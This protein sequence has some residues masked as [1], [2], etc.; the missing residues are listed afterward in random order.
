MTGPTE[1]DTHMKPL[2]QSLAI[3][4]A[5]APAAS[6]QAGR[7]MTIH[8]LLVAVRV[9]EP[10]LS[11]DGR[12]VAYVRTTTD[13]AK[14]ARNAEIWVVPADGSGPA[15]GLIVGEKAGSAPR[16]S[17]DGKHLA[18]ISSRDGDAQVYVADA[19]GGNIRKI[20]TLSGGV[21]AP[22]VWSPD[23]TMLAFVSD[24][25]PECADDACNRARR[26]AAD[27][28]PVKVHV[29]TRL[30]YRHWDSW[31]EN[32]RHHVFAADVAGGPAR[33]LTP[34]DFDAPPGQQ[35]DDAIRFTPD[36]K[37]LAFVSNHEGDDR[38]AWT[39]NNDIWTVPTTG[40]AATRVTANPAAVGHPVFTRDG[41]LMIV[42]AQ[43]RPGFESDRHYL[44]I[45]DRA[46][47]AK[48]TL[49]ETPDLSVGDFTLSPDERSIY[50]IATHNGTDNLY[51]VP[52]AGGT[53]TLVLNGGGISAVSVGATSLVFLSSTMTMPA[54][55][56]HLP[57]AGGPPARLTHENDAWLGEV[58]AKAPESMTTLGAA[59]AQVQYWV[60]KP[61]GFDASRKYPVVFLIHGGP[62]GDWGDAWSYRWNPALWAAQGWIVV[63]PNPR[64]STGFGQ[65]FV[66]EIS[67]DWGGK[68]MDDLNAV[69]D[70]AVKLP[71]VD[72][73]RQGIAGASYGGYAV[74]WIIGHTNRFKAAVSHDGVF[75]ME[76][77]SLTTEELWFS[78]WEAGGEATSAA[79]RANFAKWSP[80]HFA[81]NIKTPTLV[82]TNE[83]DFR[84]PVDQGLQ[85]FT[86][87]R[88][89]GV[90]SKALV[91]PDEGH[92]VLKPLNSQRWHEEVFAW[93]KKYLGS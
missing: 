83:L 24:V 51:V 26:E 6:G 37:S 62:Q 8:D 76:S 66:D 17:P 36:S 28:D 92:W 67:Q 80:H 14:N 44:D 86:A 21:Q 54:E 38:E 34:G 22:M 73:S 30:L 9:A 74:D 41:K 60:L 29:L 48:H 70:A 84:V 16:W 68:V 42:S 33:D 45:Y 20:T 40:G 71:Y 27:K 55:I 2:M 23:G 15:K 46:T 61:P 91:F 1:Q 79:A 43:R 64:G 65:Q 58:A 75:N 25:Y 39:T 52:L 57:I 50:F 10:Q 59:G 81:A 31:R 78:E 18:F 49:F 4:T 89:N 88:R 13:L 12:T 5:L 69:F 47:G 53:P 77:M 93:M 7:A 56:F 85:L 72:A 87:L 3:L 63:A 82:I 90:P 11:P 19:D 32:I 35:E